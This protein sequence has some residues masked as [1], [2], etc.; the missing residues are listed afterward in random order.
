MITILHCKF[1]SILLFLIF[2]NKSQMAVKIKKSEKLKKTFIEKYRIILLNEETFEDVF[3]MRLSLLNVFIFLSISSLLLISLTTILIAFTPLREYI[4][5][6]SSTNLR[7]KNI[8]L[9]TKT[10]SLEKVIQ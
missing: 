3:S 5:G 9:A 10:D 1:I 4:P 2:V 8:D 7:R 6:Y